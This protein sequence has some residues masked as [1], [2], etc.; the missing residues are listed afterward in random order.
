MK[1]GRRHISQPIPAGQRE[2]WAEDIARPL[3]EGRER[4][5][6]RF[7]L[8]RV[9]AEWF[10]LDPKMFVMA[11]PPASPQRLPHRQ[12][13]IV[14][15]LV[16]AD[17]RVIICI[18][19]DRLVGVASSSVPSLQRRLLVIGSPQGQTAFHADE[20]LGLESLDVEG[21]APLPAGAP[22]HLR[23][24]ALGVAVQDGRPVVCLD[25]EALARQLAEILQ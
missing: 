9:G 6:K 3:D 17:G 20:V 18:A 7:F 11:S 2:E 8:F 12:G 4:A 14:E 5:W 24:C 25:P 1:Q 22:G 15:G 10:A 16:N 23:N 21:L 19:F 13:S